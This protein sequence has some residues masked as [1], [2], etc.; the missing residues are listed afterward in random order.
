M[1]DIKSFTGRDITLEA[2]TARSGPALAVTV[3]TQQFAVGID[4][5][6]SGLAEELGLFILPES[7]LPEVEERG[8][9]DLAAG[10]RRVL[11][12]WTDEQVHEMIAGLVAILLHRQR[13]RTAEMA[14]TDA[15]I[16]ALDSALVRE[17]GLELNR[18]QLEV[19]HRAGVRVV[20]S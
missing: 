7:A 11:G 6:L 9:G 10:S 15:E 1:K 12:N 20:T 19:L 18:N 13:A 3:G 4:V 8:D 16:A 14:K 2:Y 5:L 17:A